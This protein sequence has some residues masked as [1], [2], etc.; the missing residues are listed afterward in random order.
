MYG[1]DI[2][3]MFDLEDLKEEVID[4]YFEAYLANDP[5]HRLDHFADVYSTALDILIRLEL[6]YSNKLLM[7]VSYLHDLYAWDRDV[8]HDRSAD[9]I[10]TTEDPI[11]VNNLSKGERQLVAQ[12]CREHR[13]SFKG[14]FSNEFCEL[15]NSAD[16][17]YPKT[18]Q[19]LLDRSMDFTSH[20][21]PEWSEK[22]VR[23]ESL[24]HI[25]EKFGTN[26]YARFPKMYERAYSQ[27]LMAM[28]Q[29]VDNFK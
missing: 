6:K 5:A 19:E 25:K 20:R 12:A 16:R 29:E 21:N 26:G 10:L 13:A 15:M 17:G 14:E 11:I 1:I 27:E 3:S 2:G 23:E 22:K 28:K 7:F 18:A 24:K 9:Y 4:F 8:H